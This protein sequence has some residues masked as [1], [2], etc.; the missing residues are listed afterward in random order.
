MTIVNTVSNI[1]FSMNGIE[2]FKNYISVV[3][4]DKVEIFNCYEREDVLLPLTQYNQITLNGTI[5]TSAAN[6]QA[7]LQPIIY[8]RST[9]GGEEPELIYQNNIGKVINI[10]YLSGVNFNTSVL[11]KI[12]ALSTEITPQDNPVFF[13]AY[14]TSP[15][16]N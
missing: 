2:Y 5:Y 8:S 10:G 3:R 12:N 16:G 6:L 11:Q 9:L 1:R 4:G 14:K 13:V 15:T 7:A